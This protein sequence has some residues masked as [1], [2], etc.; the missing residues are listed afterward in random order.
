MDDTSTAVVARYAQYARRSAADVATDLEAYAAM[1]S[2]W[3]RVQN[4]VS[5][6]TLAELWQRHIA[7][8]LQVLK[9]TRPADRAFLDLGSGGGLPAV[10]LSIALKTAD[11]VHFTLV[12]P[13]GRKAAF[14]RQVI[15]ALDLPAVVE[16]RRAEELDSRET[17]LPDVITS[18]ALAPLPALCAMAV[19]L[20][21]PQTRAIFHKGREYG[22][23]LTQARVRWDF[24]VVAIPSET[25]SDSVVLELTTLRVKSAP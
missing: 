25:S 8:S 15:R 12:E 2:R 16:D 23:E 9:L 6:E 22:E 1:L 21:G 19:R 11:G 7:D 17:G 10:P 5:R 20:F 3:Q 4:L 13:N 14:L 24:D 18:R